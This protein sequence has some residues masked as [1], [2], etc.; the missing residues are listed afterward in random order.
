MTAP[1]RAGDREREQTAALLGQAL[2]QGYLP[3][4]EYETRLQ[5]AFAAD[6]TSDL[7]GLTADLPVAALRP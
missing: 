1:V 7:R 6:T 3:M 5:S 4:D 2:T